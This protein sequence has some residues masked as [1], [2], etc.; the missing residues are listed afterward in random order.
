[1]NSLKLSPRFLMLT[2]MVLVAALIRLLPHPPNFAPIAAMALFGGAYFNKKAFAFVIPLAALF[3]TDLFL[4]FHNTMWAVYLGFILIVGLGMIML[5]KK[6]VLTVILA[7]VSASVLF[8]VL[9]N[10]AFWAT[11]TLYSTNLTGLAVCFT[12]AIPFFHNT[13]M[14]DLFYTGVMFGLFELA[15]AKFPQLVKVKA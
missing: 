8:F 1:M 3:L 6:S 9:T 11:D 14:G 15:K 2:G 4:G 13:L 12:A 5:K 10:L 7:S